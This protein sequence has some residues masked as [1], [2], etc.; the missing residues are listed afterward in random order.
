MARIRTI[1]PEFWS[2]EELSAFPESVHILAAALL[3]YA[4]D[5]G[6]FNANIQLIKASC[7]PIREPSVTI[8]V[9]IQY[10]SSIRY[11]RTG[12]T[13]DGKV[14]GHV[15]KFK[16]HQVV[17]KPKKS[18]IAEL[19]IT[20]VVV[21]EESRINTVVVP[22]ESREEWK[23]M[24]GNGRELLPTTAT[25]TENIFIECFAQ[26]EKRI[27]ELYP[28]AVYEAERETCIAHYRKSN[29]PLDCYPVILKWFQRVPKSKITAINRESERDRILRE[30]AESCR[31]FCGGTN[32]R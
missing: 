15:I 26:N 2:H 32:E 14:Y 19:S 12:S 21:P 1:K 5:E 10:L 18:K 22:E 11:I 7:F 17:N 8:P 31:E 23:G 9:A 27:R 28:H 30:N 29:P 24:E 25:Q 13:V 16:E 3:N 6:Y 20:W 4:D